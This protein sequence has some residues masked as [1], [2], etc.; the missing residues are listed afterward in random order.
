VTLRARDAV[1][2]SVTVPHTVVLTQAGGTSTGVLGPVVGQ[3]DGSYTASFTGVQAGTPTTI[4]GTIDGTPLTGP[5]PTVRVIPGDISPATSII[6]VSRAQVDSGAHANATLQ[7]RDAAGNDLV[8]GGRLVAFALTGNHGTIGGTT[9]LDDG[10]YV[11]VYTA[12]QPGP[13]SPDLVRASIEGTAVST[14]PPGIEVV[15][16]TIS[17]AHSLLSVTAATVQVGDSVLVTLTGKDAAGRSLVTGDRPAQIG[18]SFAGGGSTGT[19]GP[20]LNQDDGTY[21]AWLFGLTAGTAST[22]GATI[23]GIVVTT[24]LPTVTVVP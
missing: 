7:A 5:G 13:G 2:C 24:P 3:G 20:V 22:V 6:T 17:P 8:T 9:D 19:L 4:T 15:A 10:R 12:T 18:F 14:P 11:A 1:G 23:D 21:T 16:G